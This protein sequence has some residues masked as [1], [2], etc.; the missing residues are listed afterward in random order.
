[1]WSD[2]FARMREGVY[3]C[4]CVCAYAERALENVQ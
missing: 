1:M 3:L 4:V 2:K